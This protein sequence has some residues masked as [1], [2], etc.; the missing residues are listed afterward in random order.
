[1][2]VSLIDEYGGYA[3]VEHSFLR[4]FPE[5]RAP[6]RTPAVVIGRKTLSCHFCSSVNNHSKEERR[7]KRSSRESKRLKG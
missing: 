4:A 5:S 1:K 7:K 3:T 6:P 2:I